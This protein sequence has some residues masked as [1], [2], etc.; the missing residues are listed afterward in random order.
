[1]AL[2]RTFEI[3]FDLAVWDPEVRGS[4]CE[5][6]LQSRNICVLTK[7]IRAVALVRTFAQLRW[8]SGKK[9]LHTCTSLAVLF[10]HVR[11][12][13]TEHTVDD[14]LLL[15]RAGRQVPGND[16][17]IWRYFCRRSAPPPPLLMANA[18]TAHV[19]DFNASAKGF[20]LVLLM[21]PYRPV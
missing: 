14:D 19:A 12:H 8:H 9:P 15:V 20:S 21:L 3:L 16:A 10:Q 1:M 4:V 5:R 18:S 17:V 7:I 11:G 2:V 6:I 13:L